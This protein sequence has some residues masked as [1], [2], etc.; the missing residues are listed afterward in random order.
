MNFAGEL[1][2][3]GGEAVAVEYD[4]DLVT[5][6]RICR[7]TLAREH[8]T[9]ARGRFL[10]LDRIASPALCEAEFSD[11]SESFFQKYINFDFCY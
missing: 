9:N 8:T 3:R 11:P 2:A 1:R 6:L 4:G 7:T 10:K 5:Q